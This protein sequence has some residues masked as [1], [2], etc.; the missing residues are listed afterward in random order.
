MER[1]SLCLNPI[2]EVVRWTRASDEIKVVREKFRLALGMGST[3]AKRSV[4]WVRV[5]DSNKR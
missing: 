5:L 2:G 3:V 4:G 1:E